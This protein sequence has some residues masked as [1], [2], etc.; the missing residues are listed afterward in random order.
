MGQVMQDYGD[1]IG[2]WVAAGIILAI[3][4]LIMV[5]NRIIPEIVR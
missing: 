2:V 5:L 3:L 1:G 4:L